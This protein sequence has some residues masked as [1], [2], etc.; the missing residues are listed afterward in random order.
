VVSPYQEYKLAHPLF[1]LISRNLLVRAGIGTVAIVVF[2]GVA[3]GA[4]PGRC[5]MSACAPA[6]TKAVANAPATVATIADPLKK[7]EPAATATP[8][9]AVV[10]EKLGPTLTSNEVI[11]GSFDQLKVE[12]KSPTP[13]MKLAAPTET[14]VASTTPKGHVSTSSETGLSTRTVRVISV[15]PDGTPDPGALL[16]QGY[17]SP[18]VAPLVPQSPATEAVDAALAEGSDWAST[19]ASDPPVKIAETN[20]PQPIPAPVTRTAP[21]GSDPATI[22]GSGA[23]IR[24]APS[25][26]RNKVLFTLAGGEK[27]TVGEKKNG[28]LHITDDQGRRGWVYSSYVKR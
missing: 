14:R 19:E 12:L 28:W 21:S 11:S 20:P 5:L 16:A 17:V 10:P 13:P 3:S 6:A 27:V 25:K 22:A 4:L 26:G 2:L 1:E 24:S 7:S 18:R 15:N 9:V 8:A 23:N